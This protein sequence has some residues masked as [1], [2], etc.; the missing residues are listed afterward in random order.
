MLPAEEPPSY[1]K[2]IRPFLARYC[3]ECHT[4]DKPKGDLNLET[5]KSL[6]EGG[7]SGPVVVA[8]KPDESRL[9]ILT[10][11]KDKLVMPP[12]TAKQPRTEE[13]ALLRAWVA[14]GAK[15]DAAT[16]AITIPDIKP[17]VPATPGVTSLAYHPNG[18]IVAA[19][20]ANEIVFIDVADGDIIDELRG[21]PGKVTS[22]AFS[23]DGKTLATAAGAAGTLGEIRLYSL[24][25]SG[26]PNEK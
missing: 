17:R 24:A 6:Q 14:A 11:G 7:K 18:K 3:L 26:L 10:G 25:P 1:S 9:V 21:H 16:I 5:Y 20:V 8:Y 12:K 2:Q 23:R 15:E 4:G 13:I 22:L 19:G